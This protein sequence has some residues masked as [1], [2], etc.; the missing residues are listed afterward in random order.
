VGRRLWADTL[1]EA[2]RPA[3]TYLGAMTENTRM[4]M[5]A[6]SGGTETCRPRP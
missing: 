3:G 5:E 4:I 2:G 6:V 1:A